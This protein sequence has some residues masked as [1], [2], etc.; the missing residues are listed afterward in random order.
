MV[1]APPVGAGVGVGDGAA[2]LPVVVR[3]GL[4]AG[5]APERPLLLEPFVLVLLG[6][7]TPVMLPLAGLGS[8]T[9][10]ELDESLNLGCL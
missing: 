9:S 7:G 8:A 3:L 1:A 5:V 4:G 2:G 10:E 6:A